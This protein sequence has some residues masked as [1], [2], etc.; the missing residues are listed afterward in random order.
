M[1]H[2]CHGRLGEDA[3]GDAGGAKSGWA[4]Y[5]YEPSFNSQIEA[6][7]WAFEF[8]PTLIPIPKRKDTCCETK[9]MFYPIA[10]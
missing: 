6:L 4:L 7:F 3:T 9:V 2:K 8:L 1:K 5:M 10:Q